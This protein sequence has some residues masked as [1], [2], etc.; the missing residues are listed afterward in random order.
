MARAD[1][2]CSRKHWPYNGTI[3]T[4][5]HVVAGA[6]RMTVTFFDGLESEAELV[7]AK[8]ESILPSVRAKKIPTICRA[9]T[10]GSTQRLQPGDE[11]VAVGFPFGIG[12]SCRP[13]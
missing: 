3:L 2:C 13:A 12:P 9:A 8:P 11:V 7:G 1:G 10:L 5:L 4:N 6:K